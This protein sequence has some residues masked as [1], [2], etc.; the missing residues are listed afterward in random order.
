MRALR[1]TFLL[2]VVVMVVLMM[3]MM[4]LPMLHQSVGLR[5]AL[6]AY[7][8]VEGVLGYGGRLLARRWRDRCRD[9]RLDRKRHAV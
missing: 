3:M 5:L 6:M 1:T 9:R 7:Q 8:E 2:V 4:V